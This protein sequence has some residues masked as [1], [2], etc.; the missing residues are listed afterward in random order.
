MVAEQINTRDVEEGPG[1]DEI[2]GVS[3]GGRGLSPS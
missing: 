1:S 3:L 2:T